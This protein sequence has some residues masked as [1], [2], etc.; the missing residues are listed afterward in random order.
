MQVPRELFTT[1]TLFTLGGSATAVWIITS[2]VGYLVELPIA[3]QLKKWLAL[4]L[5]LT[6]A[7]LA[8]STLDNRTIQTW[9]VAVVNGF[10]IFLTAVGG[11]TIVTTG[12]VGPQMERTT[13]RPT[14][15][16]RER[17]YFMQPWF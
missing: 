13:I 6:F 11:N 1:S 9:V 12:H 17:G 10:L 8:A 3:M 2:V 15:A 5:S 16:I 4:V 7:I 14:G